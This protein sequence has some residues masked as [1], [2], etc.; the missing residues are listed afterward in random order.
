MSNPPNRTLAWDACLNIR[1]LGGYPIANGG[2]TRWGTLLRGDTLTRLSCTGRAALI[3]YGVRTIIDLR[4]PGE[5]ATD[6]H[7]FAES[8][9]GIAYHSLPLFADH[10]PQNADWISTAYSLAEVYEVTLAQSQDRITN[11]LRTIATAD[12]GTVLFH[13]HAGKDRT[14]LIAMFL[15]AIAGVPDQAII[16]DYALSDQNLALLHNEILA[17]FAD[18]PERQQQLERLLRTNPEYMH[19]TLQLLRERHGGSLSYLSSAGLTMP[20]IDL[21]RQRLTPNER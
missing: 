10:D 4:S 20:E 2:V 11:V 17:R 9:S 19:T 15:L 5:I 12:S 8:S 21:L 13:C 1:D 14:G 16:A 3:D 6:R 18:Q 7:P